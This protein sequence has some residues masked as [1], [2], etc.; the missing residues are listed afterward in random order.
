MDGRITVSS[1][2]LEK[3]EDEQH[4]SKTHSVHVEEIFKV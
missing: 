2:I 1:A 4:W 3:P